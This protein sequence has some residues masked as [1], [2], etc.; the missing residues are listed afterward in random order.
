MFVVNHWLMIMA[1]NSFLVYQIIEDKNLNDSW[2]QL[3][4]EMIV[5][6]A[7]TA[8]AMLRKFPRYIPMIGKLWK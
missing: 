4:V 8:P 3:G 7:E 5:T 2:R 6:L 1:Q